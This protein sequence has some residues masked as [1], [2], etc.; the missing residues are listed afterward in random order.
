MVLDA[1]APRQG[2]YSSWQSTDQK[3][4]VLFFIR[5]DLG[6]HTHSGVILLAK[7]CPQIVESL[8]FTNVVLTQAAYLSLHAKSLIIH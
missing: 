1:L 5:T 6:T 2:H 3:A 8:Y 7:L 4:A